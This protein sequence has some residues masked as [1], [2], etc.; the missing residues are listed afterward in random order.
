MSNSEAKLYSGNVARERTARSIQVIGLEP[1][2]K[3]EFIQVLDTVA[4]YVDFAIKAIEQDKTLFTTWFRSGNEPDARD[5]LESI[6]GIV[7]T[8]AYTRDTSVNCMNTGN[9]IKI[10]YIPHNSNTIYLCPAFFETKSLV[11]TNSKVHYLVHELA[12]YVIPNQG[13]DFYGEDEAKLL[14]RTPRGA[15]QSPENFGL[16]VGNVNP[17]DYKW[18]SQ[19]QFVENFLVYVT[20]GPVY[21][22]LGE[23]QGKNRAI[24]PGYP[25]LLSNL[26]QE[27]GIDLP[28]SFLQGFDAMVTY[29][30]MYIFRGGQYLSFDRNTKRTDGPYPLTDGHFTS[31]PANFQ[32]GIDAAY[33][34]QG[35]YL[36]KGDQVIK[37]DF[38]QPGQ[39][40]TI[41]VTEGY[42]KKIEHLSDDERWGKLPVSFEKGIDSSA[43]DIKGMNSELCLTKGDEILCYEVYEYRAGYPVK[44]KDKYS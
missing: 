32:Q 19:I 2:Q 39:T 43:Y 38:V 26:K 14:A 15:L 5:T 18:D 20:S 34:F 7:K 22:R 23:N 29:P 42:P 13:E 35:V 16:F 24:D 3:Q 28:T 12:H 25:K 9:Y 10:G 31:L 6:Q 1:A 27:W 40:D 37:Y 11:G 30:Y 36:F 33:H 21:I 4:Y 8:K 44:I 41:S 17:F